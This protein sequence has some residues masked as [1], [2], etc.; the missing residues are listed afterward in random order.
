MK[1]SQLSTVLAAALAVVSPVI[2]QPDPS[3]PVQLSDPLAGPDGEGADLPQ[4]PTPLAQSLERLL[5]AAYL[6]DQEK[7]DLRVYH[8][9]WTEADLDTPERQALAARI[10]GTFWHPVFD[11]A[12]APPMLRAWA[13]LERGEPQRCLEILGDDESMG[14]VRLRVDALYALGRL[15]DAVEASEPALVAARAN[16]F[17]NG[18]DAAD[19]AMALNTRVR[20]TGPGGGAQDLRGLIGLLTE[21]RTRLSPLSWEPRL[22]EAQLLYERGARSE[23]HAAATEA[24]TFNPRLN[25]AMRVFAEMQID[26]FGF[27]QAAGVAS[28]MDRAVESLGVEGPSVWGQLAIARGRIRSAD[29]D[30]ARE[31]TTPLLERF[32]GNRELRAM[33]AA[34][35]ARAFDFDKMNEELAGYQRISPGSAAAVMMAGWA[36]SQARQYADASELLNLATE[37]EPNN[38]D[39]WT[40]LGLL[41]VQWGRDI[42]ALDA[43]RTAV[44]L[45]PFHIRADNQMTLIEELLT[46]DTL[47]TDHFIVRYQPGIDEVLAQDM[48]ALLEAMHDRVTGDGPAGIRY[49]PQEKTLIELM[50]DHARFSVRITGGTSI[51]TIAAATGRVIAMEAPKAGPRNTKGPYDWLRVMR[52]EYVHT[53]TLERTRNRIPH[54]FTEAAAVHLEDGPRDAQRSRLLAQKLDE[55]DLFDMDGID[56]GFIRPEEPEDRSLAYAQSQW[57]YEYMLG[58]FGDLAPLELMD[59]YAEGFTEAEAFEDA[60]GITRETF[61]ADFLAWAD[62]QVTSWGLK[63]APGVPTLNALRLEALEAHIEAGNDGNPDLGEDWHLDMLEQYPEHPE[64]LAE[65]VR[66]A[67]AGNDGQADATMITLLERYAAVRP[68]LDTPHRLLAQLYLDGK[69]AIANKDESAAIP[70]LEWLDAREVY[71]PAYAAELARQYAEIRQF[72]RAM[73]KAKRAVRIAPYEPEYRE[74]AARVAL[75]ARDF[76]QAER[77]IVALTKLEPGQRTHE[78]RLER[79]R[80]LMTN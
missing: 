62:K 43:L 13:E 27:S 39:A 52:H 61:H 4:G 70:H 7:R 50:P 36:L 58:R 33:Q 30:G 45:D 47:E 3:E 69:G 80:E 77:Q 75:L 32:P 21:A 22:A 64:I 23:A 41:E 55:N 31:I 40:E 57:M 37:L 9:L 56:L 11:G 38:P 34:A 66:L 25:P 79:V 76:A 63:I 14:A 48:P 12:D 24:L 72:D 44:E 1:L 46:F 65:V 8:G 15:R 49:V 16:S 18:P 78:R 28:E 2:A 10:T 60:L 59:R 51:W 5:G 53:V 74:L 42:Q 54:W 67:L 6:T 20:I 35:F 19:A 29:G 68:V 26:T 17:A 73:E 71:T